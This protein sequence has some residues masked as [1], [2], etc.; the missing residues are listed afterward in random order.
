MVGNKLQALQVTAQRS[1]LR[2]HDLPIIASA[3]EA[4][5]AA[6]AIGLALTSLSE[7]ERLL[8]LANLQDVRSALGERIDRLVADMAEMR[9][10]IVSAERGITACDLYGATEARNPARRPR[11]PG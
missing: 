2:N 9:R 5:A 4:R 10:Q 3:D 11:K 1:R 8:M 7:A 6:E